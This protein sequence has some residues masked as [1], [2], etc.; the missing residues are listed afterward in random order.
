MT[1]YD[2]R[3][4]SAALASPVEGYEFV[5]PFKTYRYTST[6]LTVSIGGQSYT[7]KPITRRAIRSGTQEDDNL[8]LELEVPIDL[9]IVQ[10]YAF[11][12][13]PAT[14]VL[15]IYRY[16]EGTNPAT[17]FIV[18][19][20]GR[21]TG[22]SIAG[23]IARIRIPSIFSLALTGNIPNRNFQAPCNHVLYDTRCKVVP[24]SFETTTAITVVG[25]NPTQLT[26]TDDGFADGFLAAGEMVNNTTGERRLIVNN[27]ANLVTIAYPFYTV[28]VGNSVKLRAGCAHSF[29]VCDTKFANTVNFGGFPYI[30][31]DNPFEGSL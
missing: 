20:K 27:V 5:G 22:F 9:D 21:V 25:A 19:W 2:D 1:I 28:A 8:D 7:P 6:E 3:E 24:A 29:T 14:L 11:L 17:D 16:H 15:T 18:L 12:V 10:D 31:G 23:E 30:P 13:S 4:V 26:V